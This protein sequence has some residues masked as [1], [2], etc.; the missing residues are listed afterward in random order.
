V[1]LATLA[2]VALD[3]GVEPAVAQLPA[4]AG[5]GQI[6]GPE[7]KNLLLATAANLR[8]WAASRLGAAA[9]P[10]V[11]GAPARRPRTS[12]AGIATEIAWLA[13][14]G[15]FRQRL[16]YERL[17]AEHL[18]P[19][20]RRDL[21]PPSFVRLDPRE[22]FPRASVD[23][24]AG[25][26]SFGPFRDRRAAEK[27]RDE[28]QRAFAL[29]PCDYAFEPRADLPLGLSCLYA[30]VR[31]CAAP[32]LA[33]ATE[34]EYR[35][36]AAHAAAWLADP[37]RRAADSEAIADRSGSPRRA[38]HGAVGNAAGRALVVDRGK[39]SIALVPLRSGRVLDHAMVVI[40]PAR[41]DEGVSRLAWPE[42]EAASD[43]PWLTAW[44]RGARARTS[45][46]VVSESWGEAELRRAVQR[47]FAVQT[48]GGN[49]GSTRGD[50]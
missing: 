30:Q 40:D 18:S 9:T 47:A 45:F 4:S 19:S 1:S 37:S 6:L 22:R 7:G 29:R 17:A 10:R 2:R 25:E 14:D 23:A 44:L 3:R 39:R 38:V 35:A 12:L 34:S 16:A 26:W 24:G 27:A 15:P 41:L 42:T 43:W 8:R 21:K 50:T 46:V 49:V 48:P 5:V 31:S 13:T 20:A 33:R 11:E 32:C 28:L 36:L